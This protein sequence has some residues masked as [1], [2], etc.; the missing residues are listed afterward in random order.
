MPT[1]ECKG[2]V[3]RT[4]DMQ[5]IISLDYDC[6]RLD[7]CILELEQLIYRHNLTPFILLTTDET[8]D[9]ETKEVYGNYLAVSLQ[10]HFFG[11][12]K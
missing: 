6:I 12:S 1:I 5:E 10:K 7:L 11:R 9:K 2:F 3:C 4:E 8:I